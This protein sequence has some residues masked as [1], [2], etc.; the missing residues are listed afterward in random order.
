MSEAQYWFHFRIHGCNP[1]H[2]YPYWV[3]CAPL[4]GWPERKGQTVDCHTFD[5]AVAAWN[6]CLQE[7]RVTPTPGEVDFQDETGKHTVEELFGKVLVHQ[8]ALWG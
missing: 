8:G 6:H 7:W 5:D 4:S 3:H 2:G 1:H